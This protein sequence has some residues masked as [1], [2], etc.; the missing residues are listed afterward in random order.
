MR[1]IVLNV[2]VSLDG[3]IEGPKGEFDWCFA[4]QD[5]GMTAF[6]NRIDTIFFGRR[7]YE[8][9][10]RMEKIPYPDK[11]KY[12]FSR[13]RESFEGRVKVIGQDMKDSVKDILR[14]KGKDI[15]LFGGV[16]LFHSMLCAGLVDELQLSVHPIML[17]SGKSLFGGMKE[18]IHLKLLDAKEY[19]SGLVQLFYEVA[20]S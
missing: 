14:R 7:S 4:D 20:Q 2:A 13:T 16:D 1:K 6:M 9:M 17:G 3:F 18:R 12:V 11:I 15:W 19:S 5:Y 8:L 10:V